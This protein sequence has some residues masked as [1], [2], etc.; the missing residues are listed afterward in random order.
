[1]ARV[2]LADDDRELTDTLREALEL[3]IG[4]NTDGHRGNG[5]ILIMGT[6]YAHVK[7]MVQVRELGA[8]RVSGKS[9][10]VPAFDVLGPKHVEEI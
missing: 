2:L 6:T 3:G 5:Q 4:I 10:P 1:M 8:L 9:Q 7:E